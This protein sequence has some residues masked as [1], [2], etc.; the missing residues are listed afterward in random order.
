MSPSRRTFQLREALRALTL[1]HDAEM[2]RK[3]AG[4]D[5]MHRVECLRAALKLARDA[6]KTS[7]WQDQTQYELSLQSPK[8]RHADG[9]KALA[10][11]VEIRERVLPK[12]KK[13]R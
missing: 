6:L 5:D 7:L 13:V 9:V 1:A 4:P 10:V 3:L 8:A 11:L 2:C 12:G